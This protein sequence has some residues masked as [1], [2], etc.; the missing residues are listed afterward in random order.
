MCLL[1]HKN[2]GHIPK[3]GAMLSALMS[4][5]L[6]GLLYFE[7]HCQCGQSVETISHCFHTQLYLYTA[8]QLFIL[9]GNMYEA[10]RFDLGKHGGGSVSQN[11]KKVQFFLSTEAVNVWRDQQPFNGKMWRV[12]LMSINDTIFGYLCIMWILC[13]I[14]IIKPIKVSC[15]YL[16]LKAKSIWVHILIY[17]STHGFLP[18]VQLM[19]KSKTTT[20]L[21][22]QKHHATS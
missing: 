13:R 20:W 7:N 21:R 1:N 22:S 18:L 12:R 2:A 10:S 8:F 16:C 5:R 4:G 6:K 17:S 19:R 15:I 14:Y 11:R 3:E 9:R